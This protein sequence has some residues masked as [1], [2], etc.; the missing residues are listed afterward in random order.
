[1]KT[2]IINIG[3]IVSGDWRDS[4]VNGD[5]VLIDGEHFTKVGA[6]DKADLEQCDLVIDAK[7]VTACPGFIDSHVHIAFGDY[8]PRFAST[9]FLKDYLYGGT[10]T[11]IS[12]SE[13]HVPG[14]P[15][16]VNGVKALAVAAKKSWDNVRPG[17]MR[18]YGG[19]LLLEPGLSDQDFQ[20]LAGH[21]IWLA[22]AGFGDVKTPFDYVPLIAAAKRAGMITNV[23]TG[24]A[25]LSLANSIY[26]E[27]LVAMQPDVSFHVNGGPIAMPDA[28]FEL[29]VRETKAALQI[30]QAGNIRTALKTLELVTAYNCFERFLIGTDTPTG[31]GV[32]PEG[33]IKSVV[34]MCCLSD[35]SPEQMLAAATGNAAEVYRL[36]S[37][38]LRPG[39][40]ADLLLIDA[41]VGGSKQ[42]ALET[43]KN[44]DVVADVCCITAGIVRYIGRSRCTPPPMRIPEII[45]NTLPRTFDPPGMLH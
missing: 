25:S 21:G 22:K 41:P 34:E 4:L 42:T 13:V 37:G 32:M 1:M 43:I 23:H 29:V 16:D 7:G 27:H 18:V 12:A 2:A 26:G 38:F 31:I 11:A 35:Y 10:T 20:E 40:D 3:A 15:T 28:D 14:R 19:N 45:K 6:V 8:A 44:G 33:M 5:A 24:G 30:C 36:N 39:R 17:G 9:G